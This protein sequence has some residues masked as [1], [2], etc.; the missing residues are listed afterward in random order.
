VFG[1]RLS[2]DNQS[3]RLFELWQSMTKKVHELIEARRAGALRRRAQR[4]QRLLETAHKRDRLNAELEGRPLRP[5][6]EQED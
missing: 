3:L 5:P 4:N 2:A 1:V 6:P